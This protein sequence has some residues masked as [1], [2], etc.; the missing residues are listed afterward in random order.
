MPEP[1]CWCAPW[2]RRPADG[3]IDAA[4]RQ[5]IQQYLTEQGQ[6]DAAR[7]IDAELARLLD[8]H[9]LARR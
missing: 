4:E 8:P 7:W 1:P 2:W 6:P 3:H 5:K 9:A